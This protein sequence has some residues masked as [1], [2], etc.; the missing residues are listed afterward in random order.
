VRLAVSIAM[1]FI[2]IDFV[3]SNIQYY[4]TPTGTQSAIEL[5]GRVGNTGTLLMF[6]V[7]LLV[8]LNARSRKVAQ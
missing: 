3:R 2:S 8:L 1:L 4:S 7:A 6:G 5:A